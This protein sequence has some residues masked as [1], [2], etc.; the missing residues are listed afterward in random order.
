[1]AAKGKHV[2]GFKVGKD[3]TGLGV[4]QEIAQRIEMQIA[5][6]I[7]DCERAIGVD[8]DKAGLAPSVR[9]IHMTAQ[10][11]I[12]IRG[13]EEGVGNRDDFARPGIIEIRW[14]RSWQI[15]MIPSFPHK[16]VIAQLDI[17]GAV[18]KR[19]FDMHCKTVGVGSYNFAVHAIAAAGIELN[20]E[21]SNRF[22]FGKRLHRRVLRIRYCCKVQR[23]GVG[24]R[25]ESGFAA[26]QGHPRIAS[27]IHRAKHHEREL[28]VKIAVLVRHMI[29]DH[30]PAEQFHPFG[31]SD[32]FLE[33]HFAFVKR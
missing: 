12:D 13:Y 3:Q 21:Q 14:N 5:R 17:L 25:H 28:L 1:M 9:G 23:L 16:I 30:T 11:I 18:S 8:T 4:Q 32:R 33:R 19:M 2:A 20:P 22:S 29:A 27:I 24:A 15:L 6:E 10:H 31:D 7:G 26:H